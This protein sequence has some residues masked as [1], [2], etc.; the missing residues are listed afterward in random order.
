M[1]LCP[2]LII[3]G[4]GLKYLLL[5]I[6]YAFVVS[7]ISAQ[8][9]FESFATSETGGNGTYDL[10]AKPSGIIEG[11]LLIS[12]ACY[13]SGSSQSVSSPAGWTLIAKTDNGSNIGI[14]T[15][16]KV[17]DAMDVA[18]A[19]FTFSLTEDKKW[20]LGISRIS[21][22]DT[23]SPIDIHSENS[24]SDG[25]VIAASATTTVDSCLVLAIYGNKKDATY[26]GSNNEEY[27]VEHATGQIAS[28]MLETFVKLSAGST[29]NTV[30]IPSNS[31]SWIAQQ[32]AIRKSNVVLLN[33]YRSIASGNYHINTTWERE[34]S[35]G[36]WLS[37]S[38]ISPP[39]SNANV[40]VR[41]THNVTVND[42]LVVLDSQVAIESGGVLTIQN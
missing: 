9:S 2:I 29:G 31:E 25:N 42:S 35:D 7:F 6:Q 28:Q 15:F 14:T 41:D 16:Y 19:T 13:E 3:R 37:P 1:N 27:E 36:T 33:N 17:V 40:V 32:I 8:P 12:V 24:G 39:H 38:N 5:L 20:T 10:N 21:G 26:V 11:D 18:A 22:V 4:I 23:V 34:R 30:A